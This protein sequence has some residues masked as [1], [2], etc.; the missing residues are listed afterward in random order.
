MNLYSG[1]NSKCGESGLLLT[2]MVWDGVAQ[3]EQKGPL[4]RWLTHFTDKLVLA[5]AGS[6]EMATWRDA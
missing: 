1:Q 2:H 4:L 5:K 3:L 6:S